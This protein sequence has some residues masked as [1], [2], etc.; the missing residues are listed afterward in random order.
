MIVANREETP[1]SCQSQSA[2]IHES[3]RHQRQTTL[4]SPR[5][6][7]RGV[8]LVRIAATV[9]VVLAGSVLVVAPLS[10]SAAVT[11]AR[12]VLYGVGSPVG[13]ATDPSGN[14]F[15]SQNYSSTVLVIP[16]E[17]GTIFGQPVTANVAVV[18]SAATG[19]DHATGL[20]TD[21]AGDLFIS[22]SG[23]SRVDV[24]AKVSGTLFG[25]RVTA[26]KCVAL[27]AISYVSSPADLVIGPSGDLFVTSGASDTVTVVPKVSGTI[28]GQTVVANVAATV[29]AATR[30]EE[31]FGLAF[32]AAGNLYVDNS[33]NGAVVVV[34]H[35]SGT[36]FG[37]AVTANTAA[38]LT[39]ASGLDQPRAMAVTAAGDLLI[40][41]DGESSVTVVA[42]ASGSVFG[43]SVTADESS[44]LTASEG[45]VEPLAVVLTSTG[46]LLIASEEKF[47]ITV[48]PRVS[49]TLF[50]Q[51]VTANHVAPLRASEIVNGPNGVVVDPA[52]NLF[53]AD[54]FSNS[55][56]VFPDV[57]GTLFGQ[58]VTAGDP[59]RLSAASGL[60]EPHGLAFDAEGD[61]FI[62]NTGDNDVVVIPKVS[63]R[64][65]GQIVT[66]NVAAT[67]NAVTD[68][69]APHGIAFDH[70][71]NLYVADTGHAQVSVTPVATGTLFGQSVTA[72]TTAVL[73]AATGLDVPNSL[74]FDAAGDLFVTNVGL[75]RVTMVPRA[76][77]SLFGQTVVAN[78]A[79]AVTGLSLDTEPHGITVNAAGDLF[80]ANDDEG[81]QI[82]PRVSGT[83]FGQAV[84]AN[85]QV[86]LSG[87]T[88]L[89]DAEGV[90][91]APTG[92]LF[93]SDEYG[94]LV[95][96]IA[97]TPA[98]PSGVV[99]SAGKGL[100]TVHFASSADGGAAVTN[101][102]VTSSPGHK[103]CVT[104]TTS[105]TVEGLT[106]GQTYS[107]RVTATNSVG[108]SAGSAS[109]NHIRPGDPDT[110]VLT[111][112]SSK[113]ARGHENLVEFSVSVSAGATKLTGKV[114]V[115]AGI[116]TVCSIN[117]TAGKGSCR[118]TSKQLP[119]S[120]YA[121]TAFFAGKAP[122]AS[123][124][125]NTRMLKIVT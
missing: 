23:D 34:P 84:H 107:F 73:S 121:V 22:N 20:A 102:K 72:N 43:Q 21:A 51:S 3:G 87:S 67:V 26:N 94:D 7:R 61:L 35:A 96:A 71:G 101:Y 46:D 76:S 28:F 41:N 95:K 75:D 83:V 15:I 17:T 47:T 118:L 111:V 24:I 91:I 50:G 103:V 90:T 49:G 77:G 19:L 54:Y 124:T 70:A 32:D 74:A 37:Q 106:N 110:S 123:S 92:A 79:A 52:G 55:I 56:T 60:N 99:A 12:T 6:P 18:V 98:S 53:V 88:S 81:I 1:M 25:Q 112:S 39:A 105:C 62:V 36:L 117:V 78:S 44:T 113:A 10:A 57:T 108:T 86:T 120:T 116:V 66:A 82:L 27:N 30:L 4:P 85:T 45:T 48:V 109:S 69:M 38:T 65:F 16:K 125:S 59:V 33:G 115:L 31:P 13:M 29:T 64:I 58:H 122:F 40:G 11:P 2:A 114:S 42:P 63:G 8:R 93:E 104:S 9:S 89:L 14:L 100:A 97:V 119:V 5:G 68:L 80:V